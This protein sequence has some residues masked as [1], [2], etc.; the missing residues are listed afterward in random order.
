MVGG[1]GREQERKD[2]RRDEADM[3]GGDEDPLNECM[4]SNVHMGT[5]A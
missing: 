5:V 3:S 4:A 1:E 2:E